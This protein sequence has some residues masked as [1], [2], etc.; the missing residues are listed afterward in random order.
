MRGGREVVMVGK[1]G[2]GSWFAPSYFFFLVAHT[3]YFFH[4]HGFICTC[5]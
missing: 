3:I 1:E 4:C 2:A 5:L